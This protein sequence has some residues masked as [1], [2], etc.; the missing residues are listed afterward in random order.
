MGG[1]SDGA[2]YMHFEGLEFVSALAASFLLEHLHRRLGAS[3]PYLNAKYYFDKQTG[4]S[5]PEFTCLR[6]ASFGASPVS[7]FL[8][9]ACIAFTV[10]MA[11]PAR[12]ARPSSSLIV[13]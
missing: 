7:S 13:A 10:M 2:I 6:P 1:P 3:C 9:R 5:L 8:L 12:A 4:A 11:V